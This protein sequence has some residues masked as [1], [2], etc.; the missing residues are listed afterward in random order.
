MEKEEIMERLT[1]IFAELFDEENIVLQENMSP[2]NVENWVSIT[3]LMLIESIEKEFNIRFK[4]M[5]IQQLDNVG[6]IIATIQK[7]FDQ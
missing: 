1:P 7:H 2:E 6:N 3:Q 4:L 5:E